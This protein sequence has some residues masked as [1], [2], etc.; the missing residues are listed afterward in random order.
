MVRAPGELLSFLAEFDGLHLELPDD[1]ELVIA[2]RRQVVPVGR[3]PDAVDCCFVAIADVP[4]VFHELRVGWVDLP[5]LDLSPRGSPILGAYLDLRV[6][7]I[8]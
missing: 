8:A 3:E 5:L 4:N 2:A 7:R 6:L 1:D